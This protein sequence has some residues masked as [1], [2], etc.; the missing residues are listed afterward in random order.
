MINNDYI[1]FCAILTIAITLIAGAIISILIE[2]LVGKNN[3]TNTKKRIS[4]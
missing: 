3:D 4:N 2:Y 1:M